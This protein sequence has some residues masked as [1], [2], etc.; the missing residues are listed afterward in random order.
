MTD[1][2]LAGS[3]SNLQRDREILDRMVADQSL[4]ADF[5][6]VVALR[7]G[8]VVGYK[9]IAQGPAGTAMATPVGLLETAKATGHLERLDW[10]FRCRAFEVAL[11]AGLDKRHRLHVTFESETYG[12][13][14]PPRLAGVLGRARRELF[15]V[16]DVPVRAYDDPSGL[17]RGL[18]ENRAIGWLVAL[19]D[20][21]DRPD[22]IEALDAIRPDVIKVDFALP[23]RVD[24]RGPATGRDAL[25]AY[26]T[27]T[28]TPLMIENVDT[29]S[30]R[31]VAESLGA[32]YAR[33]VVFGTPAPLPSA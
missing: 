19:D 1:S 21:C 9:A 26:V 15:V 23:G 18:E 12:S 20:V 24:G 13:A 8:Q 2:T 17:S 30:A 25:L 27:R 5:A 4:T 7:S 6:P 29:V 3:V 10:M 22:V 28:S 14:C 11:N 31:R 16:V 32:T 33:G